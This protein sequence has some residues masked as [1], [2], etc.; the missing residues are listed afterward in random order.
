MP[1]ET[2]VSAVFKEENM[3]TRVISSA[4]GIA[5]AIAILLLSQF[6]SAFITT[7]IISL[8]CSVMVMEALS[9]RKLLKEFRISAVCL[10]FS[11]AMPMISFTKFWFLPFFVYMVAMLAVMV[12]FHEQIKLPSIA[13]AFF[14]TT[15]IAAG[16]SS[17]TAL[18][19]AFDHYCAFYAVLI[20]ATPW[21]ADA[22]AYFVGVKFGAHKLCPKIS[23]KKTVEGAVGGLLCGALSAVLM[24]LIF[25]FIFGYAYLNYGALVLIGLIN[26]PLS[27]LGDLSFSI[28][29]RTL[30][31]KDYGDLIPGHGGMLDR[32]DSVVVTAPLVL[33]VS[34]FT[35][36]II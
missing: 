32:F 4:V 14:M 5:S 35:T 29:K 21:I 20:L 6:V 28:I 7:V 36:I 26:T 2:V 19:T 9:A 27:M 30:G 12:F 33:V 11:F 23:P 17:I 15:V 34:L 22:G 13:Y 10:A 24:G 25:D 3:K 31:I 1:R 18:T 16:M 8:I